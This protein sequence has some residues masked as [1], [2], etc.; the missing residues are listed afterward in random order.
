MDPTKADY[1]GHFIDTGIYFVL[2]I[3]VLFIV[4]RQIRRKLESGAIKEAKAKKLSKIGWL[5][6]F[7]LIGY[8][9]F[10]IF[11]G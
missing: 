4:P 2:G 5:V 11:A 9:V 7:T 3:A 1:I 8:G 6:G 10:R